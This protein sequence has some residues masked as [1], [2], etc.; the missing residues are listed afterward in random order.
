MK[1]SCHPTMLRCLQVMKLNKAK[2][3][4]DV[5]VYVHVYSIY[6]HMFVNIYIYMYI[7]MYLYTCIYVCDP[8]SLIS[9]TK[10]T[11]SKHMFS[12]SNM[13]IYYF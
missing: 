13:C 7:Y 5:R 3:I 8:P 4:K 9:E 1:A 2:I 11:S 10:V 12:I 6:V